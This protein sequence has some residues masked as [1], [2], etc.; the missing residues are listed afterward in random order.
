[1]SKFYRTIVLLVLVALVAA[2]GG[3]PDVKIARHPEP[4]D[5]SNL[6]FY[7]KLPKYDPTSTNSFQ[8]DLRSS[9]LSKFDLSKSKDDLLYATFDSKT[10]WPTSDK[11]PTD[12]NWQEIM[13]IGKDPGLGVRTLHDQGVTGKG[14][15]I[16]I[17][18]QTLLIDHI[19]YK[20]RIR[21]Y[22]ETEDITGG[23][24]GAQMHGPAVVSI[25]VGH[26]VGVAPDADLYFIATGDC[27]GAT[28]MEDFDSSCRAK[29]I[30]RIIG[31]N[32]RLP[33]D[34]KIRVLSMSFSWLPQS[35]G[36]DE[37]TAAVGEAKTAGIFVISVNLFKTD[38]LFFL[39]LGREPLLDANKFQSYGPGLEWR[40]SYFEQGLTMDA[41]LVPMNSRTTA[42]PTGTEDYVFYRQGGLSWTVPYLAGMYA[43]AV[44][45]KPDITPDEFWD[46]ALKTGKTIQLQHD[47]KEYE[48]GV[49]L[50]PQALV[51]TIKD[52]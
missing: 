4:A 22:E 1:M 14:V 7:T 11:M 29:A 34:R 43:L 32:K 36:Y 23:W 9:N 26:T 25:A 19:E 49:I 12:F 3:M 47:G 40:Q 39:G 8:M 13:E 27:G 45:V 28:S 21:V 18:D 42:S 17:I 51:N 38:G 35:K 31:I 5:Y 16:A 15:G 48:F 2:C 33:A 24:R 41:L 30:R 50:N 37:I 6:H 10:Q 52:K 44:Q 46:T 20:D